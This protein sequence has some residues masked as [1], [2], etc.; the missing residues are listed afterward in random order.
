MDKQKVFRVI[1]NK[2]LIHDDECS[3]LVSSGRVTVRM[4]IAEAR[5]LSLE[6]QRAADESELM[7][8]K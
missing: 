5:E 4:S 7:G 3:V 2:P 8:D 6:I 1:A